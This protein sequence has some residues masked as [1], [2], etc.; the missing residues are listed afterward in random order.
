M[1]L[2]RAGGSREAVRGGGAPGPGGFLMKVKEEEF[3]D[4]CCNYSFILE[5]TASIKH[6]FFFSFIFFS[7]FSFGVSF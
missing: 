1:G 3:G 4:L 5:T 7:L 6:R 2:E